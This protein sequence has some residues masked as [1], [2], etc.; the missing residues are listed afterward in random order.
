MSLKVACPLTQAFKD[1]SGKVAAQSEPFRSSV[2]NFFQT[3]VISR[4]SI[5]MAKA[6]QA[7]AVMPHE[8]SSLH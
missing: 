8:G 3:D 4:T 1:R 5:N 2:A 7:R 6:V